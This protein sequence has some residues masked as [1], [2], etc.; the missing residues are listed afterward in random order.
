MFA[1]PVLIDHVAR[2][3]GLSQSEARRVV[4]DVLSFHHEPVEDLVRR[5]HA[6]L[7][8][9]GARNEQVFAALATELASRVVAGP[10][11]TERQVRRIVYG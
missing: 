2:T 11:L 7:R 6:E 1:D 10:A 5:R 8:S 3:T 4:V 9:A